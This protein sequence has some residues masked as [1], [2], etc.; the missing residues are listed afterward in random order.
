MR[1]LISLTKDLSVREDQFTFPV[2]S[3]VVSSFPFDKE[4]KAISSTKDNNEVQS[5]R[6]NRRHNDLRTV[7][8][9][10]VLVD[11]Q[12][13]ALLRNV[14]TDTDSEMRNGA[15]PTSPVRGQHINKPNDNYATPVRTNPALRGKVGAAPPAAPRL[16]ARTKKQT[17]QYSGQKRKWICVRSV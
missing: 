15:V 2:S 6:H 3:N 17:Y 13:Q 12:T 1:T 11:M 8:G 7:R 4:L 5:R 14:G 10:E 9:Q 16:D